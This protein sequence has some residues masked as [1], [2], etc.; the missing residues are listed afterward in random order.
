MKM[1]NVVIATIHWQEKTNAPE[2]RTRR[3]LTFNEQKVQKDSQSEHF[4]SGWRHGFMLL[5]LLYIRSS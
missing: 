1:V 2:T 5:L 4:L 3:V